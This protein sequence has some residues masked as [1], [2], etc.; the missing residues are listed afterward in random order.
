MKHGEAHRRGH[1]NRSKTQHE[2][3]RFVILNGRT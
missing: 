2:Q 3:L 1:D